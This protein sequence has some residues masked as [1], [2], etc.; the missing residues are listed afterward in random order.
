MWPLVRAEAE[1]LVIT[2]SNSI[3][4]RSRQK[5][6]RPNASLRFSFL[7]WLRHQQR[8]CFSLS[9]VVWVN[10]CVCSANNWL[11]LCGSGC[12]SGTE[13]A[14]GHSGWDA[15]SA[16]SQHTQR[17][18]NTHGEMYVSLYSFSWRVASCF[19][20]IEMAQKLLNS[21]LAELIGKMKLAQQYVMTR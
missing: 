16:S 18:K 5:Q 2:F 20:Q 6:V 19:H 17:G 4:S 8:Q 10:T 3:W 14:V 13:D 9:W 12:G 1:V 21:D 15:T 7:L 11:F